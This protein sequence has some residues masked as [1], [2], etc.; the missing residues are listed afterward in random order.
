VQAER[1]GSGRLNDRLDDRGRQRRVPTE[2][3]M[4]SFEELLVWRKAHE[5]GLRAYAITRRLPE[6]EKYGLISQ[7][8][9]AAV[10]IATNI[11]EGQERPSPGDFAH[12]I[13]ISIG[14]AAELRYL[15]ILI[16]DLGYVADADIASL[17]SDL[18][19]LIRML[20][21]FRHSRE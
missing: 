15:L 4:G 5:A 10:S 1:Q 17:S 21:T 19:G 9:R 7:M 16:R 2:A 18:A 6:D 14:S 13:D 12:F 8:R 11:V 20:R 3:A